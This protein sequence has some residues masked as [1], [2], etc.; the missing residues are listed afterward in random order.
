MEF[1]VNRWR[2]IEARTLRSEVGG[3]GVLKAAATRQVALHLLVWVT[4]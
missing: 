2:H 4:Q 3:M 1:D